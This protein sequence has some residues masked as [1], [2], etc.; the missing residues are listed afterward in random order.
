VSNPPLDPHATLTETTT[1][2]MRPTAGATRIALIAPKILVDH[3]DAY[4]IPMDSGHHPK[5]LFEA[6]DGFEPA[7]LG[8]GSSFRGS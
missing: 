4:N 7:T 5:A 6:D 1:L 3:E 8:L 2:A